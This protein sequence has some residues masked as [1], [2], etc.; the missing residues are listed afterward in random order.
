MP[1][2]EVSLVEPEKGN[3]VVIL[4][5]NV[6]EQIGERARLFNIDGTEGILKLSSDQ[7]VVFCELIHLGKLVA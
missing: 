4:F 2:R 6:A 3:D 7:D 5:S 1:R